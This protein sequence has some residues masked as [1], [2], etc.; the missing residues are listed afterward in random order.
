[1]KPLSTTA[2]SSS[3]RN[4]ARTIRPTTPSSMGVGTCMKWWTAEGIHADIWGLTAANPMSKC[5]PTW[6]AF[7]ICCAS[8]TSI[9]ENC[10]FHSCVC[11][12]A[13]CGSVFYVYYCPRIYNQTLE[14]FS[15][16]NLIKFGEKMRLNWLYYW[17]EKLIGP[18]EY[19]MI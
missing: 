10:I 15:L 8:T 3:T 19:D 17:K 16:K 14:V 2:S 7:T 1:M 4:S 12:A 9:N 11:G 13:L 5:L 18:N 6:M